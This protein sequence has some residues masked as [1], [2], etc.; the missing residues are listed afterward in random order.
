MKMTTE[1]DPQLGVMSESTRTSIR[2]RVWADDGMQTSMGFPVKTD[3][4]MLTGT[5]RW[6]KG[7]E[8]PQVVLEVIRGA[9]GR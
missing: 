7:K 2:E 8:N 4:E 6:L 1:K 9:R 5:M 3:A